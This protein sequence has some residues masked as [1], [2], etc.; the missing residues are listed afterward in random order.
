MVSSQAID[1]VY[2]CNSEAAQ[3]LFQE[4][5]ANFP[6]ARTRAVEHC[7]KHNQDLRKDPDMYFWMGPYYCIF[8][9]LNGSLYGINREVIEMWASHN[10]WSTIFYPDIREI[11]LQMA[12]E[13]AKPFHETHKG[14]VFL[15]ARKM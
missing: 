6:N 3:T 9:P 15:I 4:F 10:K 8:V 7:K 2:E 1:F 5:M 11:D 14:G 12:A 13:Q